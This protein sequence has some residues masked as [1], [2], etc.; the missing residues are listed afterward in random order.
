MAGE[1]AI[2]ESPQGVRVD[3]FYVEAPFIGQLIGCE[4]SSPVPIV[5]YLPNLLG[6]LQS[7][8][9]R[10]E[11]QI[12]ERQKRRQASAAFGH[13]PLR[14]DRFT[15]QDQFDEEDV[16]DCVLPAVELEVQRRIWLVPGLIVLCDQPARL[17]QIPIPAATPSY[18]RSQMHPAPLNASMT[19]SHNQVR[20]LDPRLAEHDTE[21]LEHHPVRRPP[22]TRWVLIIDPLPSGEHEPINVLGSHRD[23]VLD[24]ISSRNHPPKSRQAAALVPYGTGDAPELEGSRYAAV[25]QTVNPAGPSSGVA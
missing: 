20:K 1:G 18:R 17:R 12:Q 23:Q 15:N 4:A 14:I 7:E 22:G 21:R 6:E 3:G 9:A 5:V 10:P 16:F 19:G 24:A 8:E 2:V 25:S 13:A 11:L